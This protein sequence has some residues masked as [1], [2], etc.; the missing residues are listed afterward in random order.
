MVIGWSIMVAAIARPR[1]G[2]EGENYEC[3]Y[4]CLVGSVPLL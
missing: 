1:E 4:L 3:C 2:M